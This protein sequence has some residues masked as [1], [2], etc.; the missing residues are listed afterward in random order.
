MEFRAT[1]PASSRVTNGAGAG[2]VQGPPG[3]RYMPQWS[4]KRD[5]HLVAGTWD[6]RM[7]RA[8]RCS[9]S[10]GALRRGMLATPC[11]LMGPVCSEARVA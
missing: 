11:A 7:E 9:M 8:Y 5:C 3:P 2:A 4:W 10:S 6:F 1:P